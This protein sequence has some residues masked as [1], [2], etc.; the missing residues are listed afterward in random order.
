MEIQIPEFNGGRVLVVGDV[1]LDRYWHGDASRVSPEAPV[2][3]VRVAETEERPGGAANVALNTAAL[4]ARTRL[5]GIV[6]QDTEADSLGAMLGT[7][8][9]LQDLQRHPGSRTVT[10][11]RVISRQQ[12][13]IRLDFEDGF[14]D[15]N[16]SALLTGFQMIIL[17]AGLQAIPQRYYEAAQVDGANQWQQFWH[18]T[19]P[20]LKYTLT[21]VVLLTTILA[22]RLFDQIQIMTQGGP[23]YAT[24]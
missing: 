22:F 13:L 19:L 1:M 15:V 12:Q 3:V 21:F 23:N 24:T 6:G 17:L 9:V 11:L 8:G 10:K 14:Q 18:V 4:G 16:T 2:P 5:L 20:Q 7:A